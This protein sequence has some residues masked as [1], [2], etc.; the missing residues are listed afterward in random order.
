MAYPPSGDAPYNRPIFKVSGMEKWGERDAKSE[1]HMNE[2]YLQSATVLLE[3]SCRGIEIM[4]RCYV[5]E[6]AFM[7][8]TDRW[9]A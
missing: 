5:A 7:L 8:G 1:K 6:G 9:V 3:L 4:I 2:R